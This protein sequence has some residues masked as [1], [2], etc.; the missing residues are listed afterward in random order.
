MVAINRLAAA[1]RAPDA[2]VLAALSEAHAAI[3][4]CNERHD[5]GITE[6]ARRRKANAVCQR[7]RQSEDP[8][9]TEFLGR[10]DGEG[11]GRDED[12]AAWAALEAFQTRRR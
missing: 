10:M 1:A 9:W 11:G 8:E 5:D 4:D 6:R 3:S 2:E 12:L 7:I